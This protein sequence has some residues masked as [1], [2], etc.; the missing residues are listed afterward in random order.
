MSTHLPRTRD[1]RVSVG[2]REMSHPA[3]STYQI[4]KLSFCFQLET[5]KTIWREMYAR[6]AVITNMF[7]STQTTTTPTVSAHAAIKPKYLQK[8]A[9]CGHFHRIPHMTC[10]C[11]EPGPPQRGAGGCR[12]LTSPVIVSTEWGSQQRRFRTYGCSSR[13]E[14]RERKL[15]ML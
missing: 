3:S 13:A 12:W 7:I 8:P 1:W 14:Y 4:L 10:L 2:G 15:E 5:I 9:Q 6:C 11:L